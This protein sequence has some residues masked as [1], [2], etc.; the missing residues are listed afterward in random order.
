MVIYTFLINAAKVTHCYCSEDA[1][2]KTNVNSKHCKTFWLMGT[3]WIFA[4]PS[5]QLRCK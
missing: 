1:N 5:L 4:K 2:Y 3:T